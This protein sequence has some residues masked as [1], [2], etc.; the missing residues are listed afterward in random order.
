M[1]Y[2]LFFALHVLFGLFRL[3][4]TAGFV[5]GHTHPIW[6][7]DRVHEFALKLAGASYMQIHKEK[8]GIHYTVDC[9]RNDSDERIRELLVE[10]LTLMRK[11]GTT[12]AECKTGYF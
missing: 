10:R 5:D 11:S 7:G 2:Y 12:A 1:Q 4:R 3:S 8:G 6:S 9:T